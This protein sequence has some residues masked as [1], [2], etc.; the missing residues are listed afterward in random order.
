MG[1]SHTDVAG[2]SQGHPSRGDFKNP[3]E[4]GDFLGVLLI[5]G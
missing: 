4:K 2:V 3:M 1:N 5:I